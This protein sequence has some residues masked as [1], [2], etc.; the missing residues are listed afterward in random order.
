MPLMVS[1]RRLMQ[2]RSLPRAICC[3]LLDSGGFSELD[4]YG[5]WE[6]TPQDYASRAT[7]YTEEIGGMEGAAIQ[8][9]MCEPAMLQKTGL[10]LREHQ[11]RSLESWF[12]LTNLAP[13]VPFFPVLQGWELDD[14]LQHIEDY[15][16]SGVQLSSLPR[17]GV[18]SVCRR[19]H[20][21]QIATIIHTIAQRG[22]SLHGFGV[23]L[24]GLELI[25]NLLKS[26]DSMAWSFAARRESPLRGHNHKTCANCKTYAEM[27]YRTQVWPLIQFNKKQYQPPEKQ[28]GLFD[29]KPFTSPETEGLLEVVDVV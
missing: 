13:Q 9:W 11:K 25:S 24:K 2:R 26:A 15:E 27:W 10:T 12:T 7:R 21:Q 28:Y 16:A 14:Y 22:I 5:K 1:H 20:T 23:K 3:W 8:D 17:V 4:L 18:G 6:T 19:Q 29:S